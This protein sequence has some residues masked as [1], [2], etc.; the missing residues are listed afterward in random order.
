MSSIQSSVP[1]LPNATLIDASAYAMATSTSYKNQPSRS[2]NKALPLPPC[3]FAQVNCVGQVKSGAP[4]HMS[5]GFWVCCDCGQ[6]ANECLS[7]ERCAICNHRRC[8]QCTAA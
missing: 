3:D 1:N 4:V 7:P 2:M 5:N 6:L 8:S